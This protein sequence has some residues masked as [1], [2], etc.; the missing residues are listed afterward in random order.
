MIPF[1]YTDTLEITFCQDTGDDFPKLLCQHPGG[2]AS[3]NDFLIIGGRYSGLS[4]QCWLDDHP[5]HRILSYRPVP[6]K[7]PV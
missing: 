5:G 4:V 7:I 6:Q 2:T 3:L 1:G